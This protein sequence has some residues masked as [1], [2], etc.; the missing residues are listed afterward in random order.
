M[1]VAGSITEFAKGLLENAVAR[2]WEVHATSE[3][4]GVGY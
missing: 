2:R 1:G 4:G 3:S